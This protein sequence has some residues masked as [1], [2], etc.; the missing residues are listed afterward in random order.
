MTND[1]ATL[2]Q[3]P[4]PARNPDGFVFRDSMTDVQ[5]WY[6]KQGLVRTPVS[7]DKFVD[8][9]FAE[10]AIRKLGPFKLENTASTTTGITTVRTTGS[11]TF[12]SR[13]A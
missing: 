3:I 7:V 2:D 8:N 4:W 5:D 11:Q 12:S 10:N 1:V 9:H 13:S 6:V